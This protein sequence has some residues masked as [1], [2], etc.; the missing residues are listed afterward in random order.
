MVKS[1]IISNGN[2]DRRT[3]ELFKLSEYEKIA[4]DGGIRH[5]KEVGI[6]PDFML[7]DFDSTDEVEEYAGMG[8][9]V[10]R[11][12]PE[13][14]STDTEL[15]VNYAIDRGS[16]EIVMLGSTGTRLDHTLGN[17]NLLYRLRCLGIGGKIID[18]TNEIS[19]IS[20]ETCISRNGIY[21][22]ISLLPFGGRVRGVS[23]RGLKY[24]L[25]NKD[26][27]VFENTGISNEFIL[28]R[29]TISIE[30]GYM[31]MIR[32]RDY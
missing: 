1:L 11:F 27:Q 19:V 14:D 4:V 25:T 5:F 12:S 21:D 8:V 32:A 2:F 10:E 30:S 18:A 7:G 26:F 28:D 20:G 23:I 16:K 29:A 31:L 13:K 3:L 24:E 6:V 9:V 15:A 22:Y 17:I